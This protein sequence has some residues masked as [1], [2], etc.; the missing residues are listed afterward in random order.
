MRRIAS[1]WR[2]MRIFSQ[3]EPD[4]V[5]GAGRRPAL[6]PDRSRQRGHTSGAG[7]PYVRFD[8]RG[9]E[10]EAMVEPR[11]H[12]RTKGAAKR[13]ARPTAAAPHLDSHGD[14][15]VKRIRFSGACAKLPHCFG[16]Q[17]LSLIARS[18]RSWPDQTHIRSPFATAAPISRLRRSGSG[19]RH[20][21][22][23]RLFRPCRGSVR[24]P[25]SAR[26]DQVLEDLNDC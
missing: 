17:G 7:D 22:L 25:G 26:T 14:V 24:P 2:L 4:D 23:P 15:R 8:E 11:R 10:T 19:G 5:Q 1:L 20:H 6:G 12:R 3:T 21:S 9:V 16:I 18:G 13:Y